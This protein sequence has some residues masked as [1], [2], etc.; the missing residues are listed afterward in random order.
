MLGF[1]RHVIDPKEA[2]QSSCGTGCGTTTSEP[3]SLSATT[4]CAS[5]AI[6]SVTD[7]GSGILLYCAA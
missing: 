7:K 3:A 4:C 2:K 6:K 5:N 1:E